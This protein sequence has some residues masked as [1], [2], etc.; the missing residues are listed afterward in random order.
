MNKP[1]KRGGGSVLYRFGWF[2]A[3]NPVAAAALSGDGAGDN[4]GEARVRRGGAAQRQRKRRAAT[5]AAA[6]C[7]VAADGGG[8]ARLR[9]IKPGWRLGGGGTPRGVPLGHGGGGR[10]R[11]GL[12]AGEAVGRAGPA[13]LRPSRSKRIFLIKTARMEKSKIKINKNPKNPKNNFH[14]PLQIHRTT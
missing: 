6:R 1:K 4:G 12:G 5:A 14:S 2:G 3:K 11:A 8:A 13:G 7:G 10:A 9:L